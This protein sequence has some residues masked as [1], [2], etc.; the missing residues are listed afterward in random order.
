MVGWYKGQLHSS[1][2][3]IQLLGDCTN[4]S[5]SRSILFKDLADACGV[6][7]RLVMGHPTDNKPD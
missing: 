7:I 4:S 6:K 3:S 2:T 5:R 1:K